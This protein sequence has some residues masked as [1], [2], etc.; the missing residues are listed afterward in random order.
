MSRTV[1][2]IAEGGVAWELFRHSE[3]SRHSA[4]DQKTIREALALLDREIKCLRQDHPDTYRKRKARER[5][6]SVLNDIPKSYDSSTK[7]RV[8][9]K[10][11]SSRSLSAGSD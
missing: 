4:L 10:T 3:W 5:L 7:R 8:I 11:G 1:A 6:I 9:A 2:R